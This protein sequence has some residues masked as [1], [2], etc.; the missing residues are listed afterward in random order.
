MADPDNPKVVGDYGN[1]EIEVDS[2]GNPV[3]RGFVEMVSNTAAN[4]RVMINGWFRGTYNTRRGGLGDARWRLSRPAH[5]MYIS[6]NPTIGSDVKGSGTIRIDSGEGDIREITA[7][8]YSGWLKYRSDRFDLGAY[9]NEETVSFDDPLEVVGHIDLAGTPWEEDIAYGRGAQGLM[10]ELRI[11]G[12]AFE[13]LY[14]NT[15]DGDIYNSETR[16]TADVSDTLIVMEQTDRYDN[17]GTDILGVRARRNL[18]GLDWGATFVS[19][20]NGWWIGF[21][22]QQMSQALQD[23]RARSGDSASFWFEMGTTDL[24]YGADVSLSPADGLT[25]FGEVAWTSYDARW[26]AGNRVRKQGD[27]FVDGKIDVPVGSEDGTRFK[28]GIDAAVGGHHVMLSYERSAWDGMAAGEVYVTQ[29]QLPL[30][31]ADSPLM[32]LYG[33]PLRQENEYVNAYSNVINIDQFSIYELQALPERRFGIIELDLSTEL[34][35]LD[36]G[37][38]FDLAKMEWDY[39]NG[40]LEDSDIT[41]MSILPSVGGGLLGDR[42]TYSL[43][44][45]VSKDNM[46][47]RMPSVFDKGELLLRGSLEIVDEWSLYYNVRRVSYEWMEA[48][49]SMD[50][51][52]VNPH[53]ALVWS[54]VPQ[55][56]FR[57]G[58]GL[59]PLYYR[60]TPVDG[61]EIGRERWLA[62]DLWSNP[63]LRLVDAEEDLEDLDMISLMGVISF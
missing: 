33:F 41:S 25:L 50:D 43:L 4:A 3:I 57:L 1:S 35:G 51:S 47:P 62:S 59:N 40:G 31:D 14:S 49:T 11:A 28:T 30:E 53:L 24:F 45:H 54:P 56:E 48:E 26:D 34:M 27:T 42:L 60:D 20:R 22:E 13:A 29:H 23:Y 32:Y 55:V 61:R 7:D 10:G 38:E 18:F 12:T 17:V 5:E 2:D 39:K 8:L 37:L 21:E 52:F 58:Y 36:L 16:W 19:E 15:Y 6:F 44:Y 9:H 46:S 63:G